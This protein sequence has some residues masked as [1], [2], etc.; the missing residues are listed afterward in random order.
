MPQF[1]VKQPNG[2][3]AIFSTVVDNFVAYDYTEAEIIAH[4]EQKAKDDARLVAE[5]GLNR[6]DSDPDALGRCL[7]TIE[8]I[9]GKGEAKSMSALMGMK[10]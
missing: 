6:A 10:G 9:H 8:A 4:Y 5:R 3:Y 2:K 1:I 7:A